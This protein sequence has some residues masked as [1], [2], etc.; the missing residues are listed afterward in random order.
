MSKE[1]LTVKVTKIGPRW[2]ARLRE[3]GKLIDECACARKED[4][5]FICRW[6]L[7]WYNKLGGCSKMAS[8]SRS[9]PKGSLR[10]VGKIYYRIL[11]EK[12]PPKHRQRCATSV[13]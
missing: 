13:K 9:R 6:M 10:P 12:L 11:N 1:L 8:A 2:H 3:N 7:R 4:I 5:G